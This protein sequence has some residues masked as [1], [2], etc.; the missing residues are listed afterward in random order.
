MEQAH[1]QRVGAHDAT[2]AVDGRDRHRRIVEKAH[3]A[4]FRR[5]LRIGTVVAGAIDDERARSAGATVCAEGKLV[6]QANRQRASAAGFQVEVEYFRLDLAGRGAKRRQQ[7]GA[8]ARD[9]VGKLEPAGADLGEILVEP[10]RQRRVE[11]DDIALG[12]DGEEAGRCMVEIVDGM[13]Q[14]LKDILLLLAL[15]RHVAQ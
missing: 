1:E 15:A 14:F 13:L 9:E 10:V 3:E 7:G 6:E 8:V 12:I 2:V 4:D 11:I 5:A